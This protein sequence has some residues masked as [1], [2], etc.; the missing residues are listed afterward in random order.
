MKQE[1]PE[2]SQRHR[3]KPPN[4]R[5]CVAAQGSTCGGLRKLSHLAVLGCEGG[6]A[7]E[8]GIVH[9]SAAQGTLAAE[10]RHKG[11]LVHCRAWWRI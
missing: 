9:H 3:S 4:R 8:A 6:G 1:A 5:L 7:C 2:Q 11:P 10:L